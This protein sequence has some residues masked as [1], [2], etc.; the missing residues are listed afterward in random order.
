MILHGANAF[1]RVAYQLP[2]ATIHWE[3]HSSRQTN[4]CTPVV[5]HNQ[6]DQVKSRH[7]LG[8]LIPATVRPLSKPLVSAVR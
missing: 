1:T 6:V 7:F 8:I 4:T 3:S 5:V 2:S